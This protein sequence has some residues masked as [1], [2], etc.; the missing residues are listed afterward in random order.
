VKLTEPPVPPAVV[1][2]AVLLA[3]G[4]AVGAAV[5]AAVAA[6]V[7]AAVVGAAVAAAVGAAVAAVVG[8]AVGAAVGAVDAAGV[9][10]APR[11][12]TNADARLS[13]FLRI[14][15]CLLV[16]TT[17][18]V[19]AYSS[20]RNPLDAANSAA[21]DEGRVEDAITPPDRRVK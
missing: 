2:P 20:W 5:G 3:V 21:Y 8:A 9:E 17:D 14:R 18:P 12:S 1:G 6:V 15:R 7:G 19:A 4:S 11:T 13:H 10:Q 16:A